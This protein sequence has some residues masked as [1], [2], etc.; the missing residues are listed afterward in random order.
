MITT[1]QLNKWA[2][3][4]S[5]TQFAALELAGK[6]YQNKGMFDFYMSIANTAS[7]QYSFLQRLIRESKA[8]DG[9]EK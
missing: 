4:V 1:R 2:K 6:N 7:A 8:N 9:A 5:K 3:G